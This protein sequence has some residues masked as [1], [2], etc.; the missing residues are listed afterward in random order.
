MMPG[1]KCLHRGRTSFEKIPPSEAAL[2][3]HVRRAMLQGGH[4]WGQCLVTR[5]VIP[6]LQ[7]WG[8]TRSGDSE[9]W[10][11]NWTSLPE[12]SKGCQEAYRCKMSSLT[13]DVTIIVDA[14]SVFKCAH[15][16][17]SC[18]GGL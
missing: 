12:A 3:Q 9:Q 8:W 6:R 4:I 10:K 17:A 1:S 7:Q 16:H 13:W 2:E 11:P 14:S 5:P 18:Q 15:Q